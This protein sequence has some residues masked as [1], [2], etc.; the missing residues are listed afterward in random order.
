MRDNFN[1]EFFQN[2]RIDCDFSLR[3]KIAFSTT[4]K[5]KFFSLLKIKK[6]IKIDN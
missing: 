2:S 1:F 6:T 3:C 4:Q 5:L